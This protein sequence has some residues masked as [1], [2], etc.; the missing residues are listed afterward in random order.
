MAED[1]RV[2]V[3]AYKSCK[4]LM[5]RYRDPGTGKQIA[6]ST[7]T[8]RRREAEK[9]A[10]KWEAELQE[11]R[12]QPRARMT[13]EAFREYHEIYALDGKKRGTVDRYAGAL[14]VF[15]KLCRPERLADLST[16]KVTAFA[17]ELR[18]LGRTEATVACLLRHLKA[19]ARWANRQGLLPTVPR[20]DMPKTSASAKMKG[21]P[22]T[23]E[24]FERMLAA[25][26]GVVGNEDAAAWKRLLRGFWWSG[27]RL[28]EIVALRWDDAPGAITVDIEGTR[29]MLRIP[30]ESE[31]GGRDR[32]LPLAPQFEEL[33]LA[34]PKA[35]RSG[36]V[37]QLPEP[38][39]ADNV[40]RTVSAIGRAAGVVVERRGDKVKFASSHDLRRSFGFR[41]SRLVMPATLR[42]IMRH[43][44][45]TT[46]MQFYVGINAEATSDE[47][48]SA[49][50]KAQGKAADSADVAE[51][52]EPLLL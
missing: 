20:F 30:A 23:V 6:R 40:G 10:A 28:G 35:A 19:V 4:N 26:A 51:E 7:G 44:S 29:A 47:L 43:A 52:L 13:W 39:L 2:H 38:R 36:Y 11:G 48:R 27:L 32:L 50:G 34:V 45:V 41:W 46:T 31:K 37:F 18:K 3:V 8:A 42:E 9:I 1:I 49:L 16:Q 5:M 21:R 14:N 12:Y 17:S 25:T 33:L 15:E 24:E 22:I